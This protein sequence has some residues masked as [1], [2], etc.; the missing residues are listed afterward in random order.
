MFSHKTIR[1]R[2]CGSDA[3]KHVLMTAQALKEKVVTPQLQKK[4]L[5]S[6][7]GDILTLLTAW[8]GIK[9]FKTWTLSSTEHGCIY[10]SAFFCLLTNYSKRK[11][12]SKVHVWLPLKRQIEKLVTYV[13]WPQW[14]TAIYWNLSTRVQ[15]ACVPFRMNINY[16]TIHLKLNM[17]L[18]IRSWQRLISRRDIVSHQDIFCINKSTIKK[19]FTARW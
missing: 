7:I 12:C 15:R 4:I 19:I 8:R 16:K 14:Y 5:S 18:S 1:Y 11:C 6:Y 9:M 13:H 10:V 2:Q 3:Y 17:M